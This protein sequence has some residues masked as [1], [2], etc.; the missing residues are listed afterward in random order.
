MTL[1]FYNNYLN[2]HTVH[3]ADELYRTLGNSFHFVATLPFNK[4]EMKGGDDY[5]SR[6]YLLLASNNNASYEKAMSLARESDVCLFFACSQDFAIERAKQKDCGL[7]FEMGER[8]LK[9]GFV[10]IFS[11]NLIKWW[12]NYVRYF[13]RKPFYK[14]CCS[15]Y[16]AADD[17]MLG[18]YRGRH[19]KWG[20]F[21]AVPGDF[22][23]EVPKDEMKSTP[24]IMWCSRFL[25]WKH[26]ELPV[27]MAAL[28]KQKGYE[29]QLDMYG[30]GPKED[31]TQQLIQQLDVEDAVKMH[32]AQPNDKILLA[33]REHDIFLFTSDRFEGWGAVANESMANGCAIV[34]SNAI[35]STPYL[36]KDGIN[37]FVFESENVESLT[38]KV[39]WLLNHPIERYNIQCEA[40]RTMTELWSPKK[41]AYALLTLI[42]DLQQKRGCSI[43]NGL[44]SEDN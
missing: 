18:A 41:A 8:W 3:I 2:H 34:A 30:I 22:E 37:G 5:S 19:Y 43:K 12:L 14:L 28:L 27:M 15:G 32:G 16:A 17:R 33:M 10:N 29:F 11:P 13:H 44:C 7:S 24:R 35:G 42:T 23:I 38:S 26:P 21:T 36:V 6:P 40:R 4:N 1:T 20:Y 31:A 39:E 9:R 25:D